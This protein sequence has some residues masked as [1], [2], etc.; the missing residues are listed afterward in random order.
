MGLGRTLGSLFADGWGFVP[1]Q[2]VV[3]GGGLCSPDGWGRIFP[4]WPPFGEFTVMTIPE[5]FAS[6]VL[7]P[8]SPPFY[9]GA[10]PRTPGRSDPDF[11]RVSVS[12]WDPVHL[13]CACTSQE[14]SVSFP[15]VPWRSCT[16]APLVLKAK[17][18]E[19]SS[20]QCQTPRCGNL[21]WG[22]ELSRG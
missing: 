2:F 13:K 21:M 17:C 9:Q 4:K 20:S 19:G 1:T 14:G 18:S 7:S 11:Y 6:N 15:P 12:L 3:L 16:Q 22:S 10:P 8:Q 5:A